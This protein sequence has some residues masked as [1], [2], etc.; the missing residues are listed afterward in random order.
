MISGLQLNCFAYDLKMYAEIKSDIDADTFQCALDKLAAWAEE[1]Q[2]QISVS[3]CSVMQIAPPLSAEKYYYL[4]GLSLPHTMSNRDLG[5]IVN[6]ALTPCSH[7]AFVTV[8]VQNTKIH[9]AHIVTH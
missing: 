1:W 5:V 4:N 6:D 7:I 9:N 8:T 2:L 3:K